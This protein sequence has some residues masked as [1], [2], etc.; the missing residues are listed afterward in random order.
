MGLWLGLG[1][2]Q[3][4]QLIVSTLARVR[5]ICKLR[6]DPQQWISKDQSVFFSQR[7]SFCI[8]SE[9]VVFVFSSQYF[10]GSST[11]A[12]SWKHWSQRKIYFITI[13][14]YQHNMTYK[15]PTIKYQNGAPLSNHI[16]FSNTSPSPPPSIHWCQNY[17][18]KL[19]K[20]RS[21]ASLKLRL[22][23][24]LTY[25]LTGVKCR[26]TSVAKKLI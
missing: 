24:S 17:R 1:V 9:D 18:N 25:L 11:W 3:L 20:P 19:A 4:L 7:V 12:I 13:L 14:W 21:Y 22:T 10:Q 16:E 2:V 23:D 15:L 8:W 26:A 5:K 6:N